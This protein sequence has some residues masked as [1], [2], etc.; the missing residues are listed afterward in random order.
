MQ[1]LFS[2]HKPLLLKKLISNN[3]IHKPDVEY[4]SEN[5]VCFK[6]KTEHV[7]DA[8]IYCT[9]NKKCLINY[10]YNMW[11]GFEILYIDILYLDF[12]PY[13]YILNK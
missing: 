8:I 1:V 2:H 12:R 11:I 4:F 6:D 9:G 5:T 10:Q 13:L 7:L 3:I